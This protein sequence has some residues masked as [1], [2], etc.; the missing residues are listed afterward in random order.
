[1]RDDAAGVVVGDAVDCPERPI[2]P[3][4]GTAAVHG[5]AR[6]SLAF[7]RTLFLASWTVGDVATLSVELMSTVLMVYGIG[8]VV[9]L[10]ALL[11]AMG[12]LRQK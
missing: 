9:V 10:L 11:G 4:A 7:S 12:E 2:R 1:M 6:G 3:R 8:V 5:S